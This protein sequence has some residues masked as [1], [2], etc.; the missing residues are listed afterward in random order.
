MMR[1]NQLLKTVGT[2]FHMNSVEYFEFYKI[3]IKLT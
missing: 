1:E 3:S 2:G